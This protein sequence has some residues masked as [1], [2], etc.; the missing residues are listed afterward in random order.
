MKVNLLSL[1][2]YPTAMSHWNLTPRNSRL[3][4]YPIQVNSLPYPGLFFS[5]HCDFQD[6]YFS[7]SFKQYSNFPL[8]WNLDFTF[9]EARDSWLQPAAIKAI[10]PTL[11]DTK[12]LWFL[13]SLP[14]FC[15]GSHGPRMY[16]MCKSGKIHTSD[17]EYIHIHIYIHIIIIK[18]CGIC[19]DFTATDVLRSLPFLV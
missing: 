2:C 8:K 10:S 16:N 6:L 7:F 14:L 5:C 18:I 13:W 11:L 3:T 19:K 9:E 17:Y 15:V 4:P 1:H 12:G